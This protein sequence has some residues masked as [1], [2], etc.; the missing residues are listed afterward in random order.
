MKVQ[1]AMD[2][3][4]VDVGWNS[5]SNTEVTLTKR[6]GQADLLIPNNQYQLQIVDN[7]AKAA[8]VGSVVGLPLI[9]G[10]GTIDL[11][12]GFQFTTGTSGLHPEVIS[13]T[14]KTGDWWV[15][16]KIYLEMVFSLPM[17]TSTVES[18]TL[19]I[20]KLSADGSVSSFWDIHL[21]TA[22]TGGYNASGNITLTWHTTPRGAHTLL[23][24]QAT[25]NAL[26]LDVNT[27]RRS[28]KKK[29]RK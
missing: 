17:E 4:L 11:L 16:T 12:S 24:M 20:S 28:T 1:Q 18:S 15:P 8:D 10:G 9:L 3:S 6:S 5:P 27:K 19:R 21:A 29:E 22:K 25:D 26:R 2:L 23:R 14:P 13:I 7:Q